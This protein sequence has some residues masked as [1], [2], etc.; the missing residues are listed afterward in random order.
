MGV[1]ILREPNQKYIY[2]LLYELLILGNWSYCVLCNGCDLSVPFC[3]VFLDPS[4]YTQLGK[5]LPT[6]SPGE[7]APFWFLTQLTSRAGNK[8]PVHWEHGG[9]FWDRRKIQLGQLLSCLRSGF[10]QLREA[11]LP[12]WT[13]WWERKGGGLLGYLDT[14]RVKI[15]GAQ[16]TGH[17]GQLE[18]RSMSHRLQQYLDFPFWLKQFIFC[19]LQ[20]WFW[21]QSQ[22]TCQLDVKLP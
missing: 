5:Q 22:T 19:H 1:T 7:L 15:N 9:C 12:C 21:K 2:L 10:P 11:A 8:H 20:T 18:A 13:Q 6:V 14:W 3:R 17:S 4:C 16:S